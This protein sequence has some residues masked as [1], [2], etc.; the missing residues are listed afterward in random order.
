VTSDLCV[1]LAPVWDTWRV[2][3]PVEL[4]FKLECPLDPTSVHSGGVGP[5]LRRCQTWL[6]RDETRITKR[7]FQR[8][9]AKHAAG[10][11]S[12]ISCHLRSAWRTSPHMTRLSSFGS[13]GRGR[14]PPPEQLGHA[15]ACLAW[16]ARKRE[17]ESLFKLR[18]TSHLRPPFLRPRPRPRPPH[19]C[20]RRQSVLPSQPSPFVCMR[21]PSLPRGA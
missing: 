2:A 14:S 11:S 15:W 1:D 20:W 17:R 19:R 9:N 6:A 13:G 3:W 18:H 5:P 10:G 12:Q 4:E 8:R 16:C 7:S 21:P